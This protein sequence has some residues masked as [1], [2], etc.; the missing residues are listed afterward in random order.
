MSGKGSGRRPT[1]VSDKEAEDNWS[2]IFGKKEVVAPGF[3]NVSN[4][5]KCPDVIHFVDDGFE[6]TTLK[7]NALAIKA[8]FGKQ[9]K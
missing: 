1:L 6:I 7:H 5:K 3:P 9:E 2:R 8:L 4:G